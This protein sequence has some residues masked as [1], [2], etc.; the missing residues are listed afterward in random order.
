MPSD[1]LTQY[2]D[3]REVPHFTTRHSTAYT[4][5]EVAATAHIPGKYLAKTVMIKLD[6]RI[7]M[8]VVPATYRVNMREF[9]AAAG[10][11]TATLATEEEFADLFPG[12]EV[13]AMPPFGNLWDVPVYCSQTLAEDDTISF[14]AGNHWEIITMSFNDYKRLV[15]PR[16]LKFSVRS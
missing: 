9:A 11:E 16:I 12:C 4:A 13:G 6:G 3:G 2:L 5:Q 15:A 10:G 1:R 8:A 7:V 14:N